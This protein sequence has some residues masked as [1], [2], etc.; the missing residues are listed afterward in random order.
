MFSLWDELHFSLS[1]LPTVGMEW[2]YPALSVLYIDPID[3]E[4]KQQVLAAVDVVLP[5]T[6]LDTIPEAGDTNTGLPH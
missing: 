6:T 5:D 1:M 4:R 3:S 2:L